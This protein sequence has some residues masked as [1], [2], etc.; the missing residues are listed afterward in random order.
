MRNDPHAEQLARVAGLLD[1]TDPGRIVDA[2]TRHR[3]E[4]R[5]PL[6]VLARMPDDEVVTQLRRYRPTPERPTCK[7]CEGDGWITD[8]AGE[9]IRK[10]DCR[11]AAS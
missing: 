11:T 4:L 2:W 9:I 1:V 6:A 7:V 5:N 10:C 8:E 3:P